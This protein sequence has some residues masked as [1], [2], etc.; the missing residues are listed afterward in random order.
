MP[1]TTANDEKK[2]TQNHLYYEQKQQQTTHFALFACIQM[3]M[4]MCEWLVF[5]HLYSIQQLFIIIV[6]NN[7]SFSFSFI[8]FFFVDFHFSLLFMHV[9]SRE[10]YLCGSVEKFI[11]FIH[12]FVFLLI[13]VHSQVS[14]LALA[15]A[16]T[17]SVVSVHFSRAHIFFFCPPGTFNSLR[18]FIS[19]NF[20][21]RFPCNFIE[22]MNFSGIS[23]KNR[24]LSE[25]ING[26]SAA[27]SPASSDKRG[28]CQFEN[29][30]IARADTRKT[31]NE[32]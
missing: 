14:F 30:N 22:V 29:E 27:H 5:V 3:V 11:V 13:I 21:F 31:Q 7:F 10:R 15:L 17:L 1:E 8:S 19:L 9:L 28:E 6:S 23:R 25:R 16:L 24:E 26:V 12:V 2:T 20:S 4:L 32:N 18:S